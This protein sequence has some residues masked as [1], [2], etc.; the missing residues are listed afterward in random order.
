MDPIYQEELKEIY[1]NPK[2]KGHIADA[3]SQIQEQNP[4]C[5]DN[6]NLQLKIEGNIIKEAK[7]EGAACAVSI[8]SSEKLLTYIEGKSVK[9]ISEMTQKRLLEILGIDISMSRIRCATLVF[10]ALKKALE[11]YENNERN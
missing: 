10:T 6:I 4:L 2:H 8:L 1:K 9:E 11:N 3:T 5:G 7:F